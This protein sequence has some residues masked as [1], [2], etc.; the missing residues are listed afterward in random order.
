[1]LLGE[2]EHHAHLLR[3][4]LRE[5][6]RRLLLVLERLLTLDANQRNGGNSMHQLIARFRP[7]PAMV[8][9]TLALLF[10][11]AGTGVAAVALVPR[12]SVGSDQVINGS[13]RSVDFKPGQVLVGSDA[14]SRSFD[15]VNL[16]GDKATPV[17]SL[18]ISKPG[19]YLI[20]AQATVV[21]PTV[22]TGTCTLF[23]H[24]VPGGAGAVP[25]VVSAV[26]QVDQT[27]GTNAPT[28]WMSVVHGFPTNGGSIDLQ[29]AGGTGHGQAGVRD[30]RITAVRL[31]G[32]D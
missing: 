3:R 28:L 7:S 17:A 2:G 21:S 6:R 12:N 24:A 22:A 4:R 31:D 18:T 5:E 20:W 32:G 30:I 1:V 11:L 10:A 16:A 13:L 9:A 23:A 8:V 27:G 19:A 25:D 29:C 14:V 15:P 26:S